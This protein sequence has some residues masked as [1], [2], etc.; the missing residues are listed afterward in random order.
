MAAEAAPAI[1]LWGFNGT[2]P[3][4]SGTV[5]GKEFNPQNPP[6]GSTVIAT[7]VWR[8]S[9]N[10]ITSVTDEL[11]TGRQVGNTYTLVE[12]VTAGGVSM[13]TY[14]ATNVQNF[15][16]PKRVLGEE[17]VVHAN[18][19]TAVSAGGALVSAFTG[20][21]PVFGQA[22]GAH[23]SATGSG[24]TPTTAHPGAIAVNAGALA[25]GVSMVT[26]G[27]IGF[28]RPPGFTYIT[29][30]SSGSAA[31]QFDADYAVPASASSLDPQWRWTFNSPTTWLASVFALNPAAG[32]AQP[33][34]RLVFTAQ[35]SST[36]TGSTI[37]PPVR[38]E[39]QDGAGNT[40]PSFSGTITIAL[41]TNQSVGT[42]SGT[43]TATAV[44][45]VA[46][47]TSLSIDGAGN[48][49][50]LQATASGL[51]GATSGAFDITAATGIA[52]WGFN[53]TLPP[54]SG[55]VLGKEFNPQNPP[56]GSTV[57]AT[58]VWRGSSNII[59]S[60]TDELWT[61]RQ[62][63]NTY[64]LVEYITAGGISMATYV[65]T[66]VQNFPS[67]KQVLGE[68]LLVRAHLSTAVSAGGALVSAW[69]GVNPVFGQALGGHRSAAGSGSSTP[70]TAH[71]GATAVN[72]GALA[73]G[74]SMVTDGLVGL[75]Q[76]P[77]F[78]Y[79]T[80]LSSG[81]ASMQLDAEYAVLGGA[82]SVDPPW[83][84]SFTSPNTWLASVLALNPAGAPSN[85][86]PIAAFTSSCNGLTCSFTS[87]SSDP[88]GTI[89]SYR[90]TFGDGTPAV[91]TQNTSHTY[92]AA[93]TYSVTLTVTDNQGATGSTSGNVTV[94]PSNQPPV[95]NFTSSCNALT[96]SFTSTSSD[97]D[98]TIASYRWT[99]GDGTPAV[100]T[101]NASHTYAAAGTYTVTLTVT[102][103]QG[104]TSSTSRSVGV[105]P[106]NQ[107]P[108]ANFTSS[109][110]ALTCSF[111]STSSDPDGAIASYR[112]TFGDGTPAVTTQNASHTYT[113]AGTYTVTLTVTDNEG[114]TN[115]ISRSVPLNQPPVATR[116]VFT[117]QPTST[118][119][120]SMLSPPV[121]VE[122][123]D[124][125]GTTDPSFS[126]TISVA[127]NPNPSGGT[128][129]GTT[130]ATAVNGVA[131]FSNLSVTQAGNGY[132]LNATASGLTG[133]TSAAFDITAL[134]GGGIAL[135]QVNGTLGANGTAILKGFNPTNPHRGD[136]IIATF[137]WLGSTN[138][139][140]SVGDH[141]TDQTPVGNTY[142]LV[143]YVTI[144]GI[145]MATYVATNVQ[146]FPD[147]NPNQDKVL[148]VQANLSSPITA[149]GVMTSAYT[150]VNP[151]M[152]QALGAHRSASGSGSST[153]VT[154]PGAIAIGAG[155]LTYAVTLSNAVVGSE[156]PAGFRDVTNLSDASMKAD[157]QY[158]V[159]ASAGSVNPQWTWFFNSTSY[160]L[161][162][163]LALNP[164]R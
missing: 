146:N 73:Y 140:S 23:R 150:G 92:A 129:S 98:G 6:L 14:V 122:A 97:A 62:V 148:V 29:T 114:A 160:W 55:T 116:L 46:T 156:P 19:S 127:L 2:L 60:V 15:P 113:A 126:G 30:L 161:A 76:P 48:G 135:D 36:T 35:P 109:C 32:Q 64:N 79:M 34:T 111:T 83:G 112:W 130:T 9:T 54:Q 37:S 80:G 100:T 31:M 8:G 132:T 128:L 68:E 141:L 38:V 134:P 3:P 27:L 93:G 96:C 75:T 56:L 149:G 33:A 136:A 82:S 84:W 144:D 42:L 63:G 99:F 117:V 139:I 102:D 16:S 52:L 120:G 7:F 18:L 4:Q 110:N 69:T 158:A 47:F 124:N 50:T 28:D 153:T 71:P 72:A 137:F 121:R 78:T 13:A 145:S 43:R 58:F 115:A 86:P 106:P 151:V 159:Q 107:P 20:V 142:T 40:D 87:T 81:S 147:P 104:A 49:Y 17:L 51:T 45:G 119:A 67:P 95:A 66:N 74:V 155:A 1:A 21:N 65:A 103:N 118:T 152:A 143:D 5:L 10:I 24:S 163:V 133:A 89:A 88:D 77:G 94:S 70:T 12:Y 138:I 162:T 157:G 61:G 22:L 125:A 57:I 123:Q 53:G 164:A 26:D 91:T 85:Q 41:G 108:V 44:N 101:Q 90:W 25:Y 131:T 39:A 105:N 11:W 59:T 154:G